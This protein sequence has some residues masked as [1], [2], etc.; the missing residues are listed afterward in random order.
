MSSYFSSLVKQSLSRTTEATLSVSGIVHPGLREHLAKQ[1]NSE[2]G[3][4]GSFLAPPMFEQTFGWDRSDRTMEMLVS[5]G[6]LSTTVVGS[7]DQEKIYIENKDGRKLSKNKYRFESGWAPYTHQLASWHS[8]LEKKHSVVVTSG[9]GSGK[10]ECFMVPVLEDLH[11]CYEANNK[12]PLEGIHALFL[13]PLNALINSQRE[14]LDAWTQAFGNGIRYCLYNGNTPELAA[15]EVA[16][17]KLHPNEVLTRETM[18]EHPAPI[19]VTNGT[20]LE[21]MM[22]RQVDAPILQKSREKKTLRWIVLDEAHTY[23]GSQAAE[24]AMQLRRVMHAFG[25]KPQDVRF[26]ATSATIAGE[27]TA[28]QL[29]TFLSDL[30]GV[31]RE[32]IDVL[33]GRRVTPTLSRSDDEPVELATLEAMQP[34][35]KKQ[36]EVLPERYELLTHS[37]EARALRH[38]LVSSKRPLKL[39][40]LANSVA[41]QCGRSFT[42]DELLRWLDVCTATKPHKGAESFLKVRAHFF[43]RTTQGVWACFDPNCSCKESTPLE[44]NWPY[45]MVYT[46]QRQNCDCGALV[47]ELSF[48]NEC[49]EPHLLA[50]D[51]NG[52]LSHWDSQQEDEFSLQSDEDFYVEDGGN[53]DPGKPSETTTPLVLSSINNEANQFWQMG[54]DRLSGAIGGLSGNLV[55]LGMNDVEPCC[56]SC[57][58]KG[59]NGSSPFRRSLLGSPFYVAN[60][61]PTVLEYCPDYEDDDSTV[62]YQNLPG[63]GRRLITFTDSRQGTARMSV[64]M[65]QEAER[66]KLRGLVLETL[67]RAELSRHQTLESE[68]ESSES[69]RKKA[70]AI[71]SIDAAIAKVLEEKANLLDSRAEMEWAEIVGALSN[72]SDIYKWMIEQ[73]QGQK[74]A[75]FDS[76]DMGPRKFSE[77]LLFR[78]F[79][80]R[81]KRK[82]SLETQG[83][84]RV[85]YKGLDQISKKLPDRWEKSGFQPNDWYD[86]LKVALD[87]YV[88]DRG[89][90]KV[91]DDWLEWIGTKYSAKKLRSPKSDEST[92]YSV[93]KWPTIKSKS[94]QHRLVKLLIL[95]SGMDAKSETT[96]ALVNSWLLFA[97]EQLSNSEL[98][99]ADGVARFLLKEKLTFSLVSE[100]F[101]C[102]VTNKLLDTSFKGLSPYLPA[103]IDWQAFTDEQKSTYHCRPVNTPNLLEIYQS[104][105]SEVVSDD[106]LARIPVIRARVNENRFVENLRSENLWT[107]INDRAVEGGFYYRSAEHSAQQ[108]ADRL[109]K[110]EDLFKQGK[111]NVLNCSTT[112]EM[113]VDIGGISAVVMNNVPPHPANYLQRA[114]R[115][116]RSQESRA[117]AY[118]LCKGNP[119][120]QQV[121]TDPLWP[122]ET[123]IPAP[124]VALNSE[125]LV[126]RHINAILLSDFLCNDVGVTQKDKHVLTTGWF[127]EKLADDSLCDRFMDSLKGSG[128]TELDSSLEFAVK[129]TGLHGRKALQL[130]IAAY[131]IMEKLRDRWLEVFNYLESEK[132]SAKKDSPYAKRLEVEQKRHMGEYLLRD[133]AARTFLP[134]YGFPTDVVNFDNFTIEDYFREKSK[135]KQKKDRED[136]ISRYKG[137]PSRNLAIAIREYAPGA[138]IVLDGRVFRSAGVSLHWYNIAADSNEAQK[139]D[140]A[141]RCDRCGELGYEDGAAVSDSL[142][143]SNSSCGAPIKLSN[144]KKVLVPAGF[145]TDAY[146][147]TTNN[148][149]QQKYIPV[150]QP[151]VIVK[152]A[153]EI[154]L[155]DPAMGFMRSGPDGMVFHHSDGEFS[156]GFAVCLQCGRAHSM[157]KNGDLPKE[158]NTARPHRSP[159]PA[160]EDRYEENGK[161]KIADCGGQGAPQEKIT[162][163]AH[164]KT[165]VFELVLRRPMSNE[166]LIDDGENGANRSIAMTL[167]VALRFSLA[168]QLGVS[169]SE[170]GFSVRPAKVDNRSVLVIQLY[171]E[172]SGGAGFASSAA[173][174]IEDI[175][176]RMVKQLG[177]SHCDTACSECLLDSSTRHHHD[178][179]NRLSALE[180]LGE[181]FIHRISLPD[182][183]PLVSG[184]RYQPKYQSKS[185]EGV[186][187][188][189]IREGARHIILRASGDEA[190]WDTSARPFKKALQAYR[191]VDEI[192]VDLILP[193]SIDSTALRED[194]LALS[195]IGVELSV[196][197]D[198]I[199]DSVVAQ[200]IYTNR[201]ETIASSE[202]ANCIPGNDWHQCGGLTV[203]TDRYPKI[204]ITPLD[205]S[206]WVNTVESAPKIQVKNFEINRALDGN[207]RNFGVRFWNYVSEQVDGIQELLNND[208]VEVTSIL[209]SDRYLQCPAYI[210]MITS[211]LAPI[212][213]KLVN[214]SNASITT[215]FKKN[216]RSG[217]RMTHNWEDQDHFETFTKAWMAHQCGVEFDLCV[218]NNNRDIPHHRKLEVEFSDGRCLR[219][220]FD[221][222]VGYWRLDGKTD[223]E[224]SADC[225]W[226]VNDVSKRVALI[227]L[228]SIESW[229]TDITAE[230]TTLKNS[231]TP[232]KNDCKKP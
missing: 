214:R 107:D 34:S 105:K 149:E 163:G 17:Q 131:E 90:I 155:P 25:V 108:S 81:P 56:S 51:K 203:M 114:G 33:D 84:V 1:M 201:V 5:D 205:L 45:G 190:D 102:P 194:L 74:F 197:R 40:A 43:Q 64:R 3:K 136:N 110:Y 104:V 139:F 70:D 164:S 106:Y 182:S 171:D 113:G 128:N 65:Q 198:L 62:S 72:Q 170:L 95:A 19:L 178:K 124:A 79:M 26:V 189:A 68:E 119:H 138:E 216:E 167:A 219:V 186:I 86:F 226:L 123:K 32:Q 140:L 9:T 28:E 229:P 152:G 227:K 6:L 175:L 208:G 147:S 150:Q 121:F 27:D 59:F 134:G 48:C 222:G 16:R 184:G 199:E 112:M 50:R 96:I 151:W 141:W 76:E 160:K 122:F 80:K 63:R 173:E 231:K 91:N 2:C 94:S 66:S 18:R 38:S 217:Y 174:H 142:A 228:R 213:S 52:V 191:L 29:K 209:Y 58:Y 111:I 100:A 53:D 145:V 99:G 132:S 166:Y 39:D 135:D 10:T 169:A 41:A 44:K 185:V 103:F 129:G 130:R 23:V 118:T 117:L 223:F 12:V 54:F 159:R 55:S 133:M 82:N 161:H 218:V 31:S 211:L 89:F 126:Q 156:K 8:L 144:I 207:L 4:P 165:D 20:M 14:R 78:E 97:W 221:Q 224:F 11:Q 220:R 35:D 13:Y 146:E 46:N 158:L 215:L 172:L 15:R 24:L 162:L 22:V 153:P 49:N 125:R 154:A 57:S 206:S 181:D 195:V 120:D 183:A 98:F 61:V 109:G 225:D 200:L 69:L 60:A 36:Q 115:A 180:W 179:L 176:Q 127:F 187:L 196:G 87:F 148:V 116:G 21:Y 137:L 37:P 168:A 67:V 71:R 93:E 202:L 143:C 83:L 210:L 204:E 212:S 192:K 157:D 230:L 193:A 7:L 85:G 232:T 92:D 42:Q 101:I 73:N 77:M 177:C 75:I 188:K 30:S 88:R 47:F